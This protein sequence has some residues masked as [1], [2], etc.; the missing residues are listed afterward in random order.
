MVCFVCIHSAVNLHGCA[1]PPCVLKIDFCRQ[2]FAFRIDDPTPCR[3]YVCQRA[4][5]PAVFFAGHFAVLIEFVAVAGGEV[6]DKVGADDRC[7]VCHHVCKATEFVLRTI[8]R[9]RIECRTNPQFLILNVDEVI[10]ALRLCQC[11]GRCENTKRAFQEAVSVQT[12]VIVAAFGAAHAG[13]RPVFPCGVD[14]P[15]V[16]AFFFCSLDGAVNVSSTAHVEPPFVCDAAVAIL[17]PLVDARVAQAAGTVIP[18]NDKVVRFVF[19]NVLEEFFKAS[20]ASAGF[21]VEDIAVEAV[22]L[23]DLDQFICCRIVSVAIFLNHFAY[24]TAAV[25]TVAPRNKDGAGCRNAVSVC[26]VDMLRRRNCNRAF[27]RGAAPEVVVINILE[28]IECIYKVAV[29]AL[30]RCLAGTCVRH[31]KRHHACVTRCFR[32]H[33]RSHPAITQRN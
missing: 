12:C 13:H 22:V 9:G 30:G 18:R 25:C 2:F 4:V 24:K 21:C 23:C 27:S 10:R 29:A 14:V 26:G 31:C 17:H 28:V 32:V 7:F 20:F 3:Q 1:A 16:N 6:C 5:V 33:G 15:R 11:N 8:S 19:L